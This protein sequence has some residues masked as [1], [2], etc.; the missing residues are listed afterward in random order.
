MKAD[1]TEVDH[2][3]WDINDLNKETKTLSVE[4]GSEDGCP[5]RGYE[6]T[7]NGEPYAYIDEDNDRVRKMITKIREVGDAMT[8]DHR[9]KA[10]AEIQGDSGEGNLPNSQHM[11]G[12]R[13][14]AEDT[15]R[16]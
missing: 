12:N 15:E 3:K 5:E 9:R 11:R 13:Y 16:G 4:G 6:G 2:N 1:G 7:I 10:I 14:E 8:S